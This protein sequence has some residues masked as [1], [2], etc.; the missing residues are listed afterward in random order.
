MNSEVGQFEGADPLPD[1]QLAERFL[2][3]LAPGEQQ[4]TFYTFDDDKTRKDV[5]LAKDLHGTLAEHA[6]ELER[7]NRQGAAVCVV[8][9]VTDGQGRKTENVREYRGAHWADIEHPYDPSWAEHTKPHA[10]LISSDQGFYPFWK[11]ED[12]PPSASEWQKTQRDLQTAFE[13]DSADTAVKGPRLPGFYHRKKCVAKAGKLP[14]DGV[15]RMVRFEVQRPETAGRH[16]FAED[17]AKLAARTR[18]F[19]ASREKQQSSARAEMGDKYEPNEKEARELLTFID[20]EHYHTWI[21]VG[22][23]L[24]S[25][26]G[27]DGF[28]IWD[29]WSQ[30]AGNYEDRGTRARWPGFG[31]K[32]KYNSLCWL[33]KEGGADLAAIARKHGK[34]RE[35]GKE[36]GKARDLSDKLL[37]LDDISPTL[38]NRYLVKGLIDRGAASVLYGAPNTGKTFLALDLALH[39][40]AGA[41]WHG[42]KVPDGERH[43]G[44]VLYVAAE[45]GFGITNRISAFKKKHP[46]IAARADGRFFLLTDRP[47]VGTGEGATEISNAIMK[48]AGEGEKIALI[49]IDTL[50]R[51][52][53]GGDENSPQGMG[54][55]VFNVDEIR[56]ATG[57]HV[58]VIHHS[59][60]D[61]SRGARGHN[62]LLG[63]VDTEFCLERHKDDNEV[64]VVK[65]DKQ[66]D[67]KKAKE[68]GYKLEDVHL[69]FDEDGE[70]VHSAVIEPV[71][72][73][74]YAAGIAGAGLTPTEV[75]ALACL[76]AVQRAKG[77]SDVTVGE[78]RAEC[79]VFPISGARDPKDQNKAFRRAREGLASKGVIVVGGDKEGDRVSE[80]I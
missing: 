54:L 23:A 80:C 1:L 33:A 61:V 9:H 3:W 39:V 62:N 71:D 67:R 74:D 12:N 48:R 40:A 26:F 27:D 13:G 38:E 36:R 66:R 53:G 42:R 78:W 35:T 58:M 47:N 29:E 34:A 55:Y 7:L 24:K 37:G 44:S 17:A 77:V 32:V 22:M 72:L 43:A 46:E 52:M 21:N 60:K 49:V 76:R 20:A 69:G 8:A 4:F 25:E 59:G 10:I 73:A 28:D 57:A 70:E 63:G 11:F 51:T 18:A 31:D 50:S 6:A 14:R 56:A 64:I 79:R 19:L 30:T 15:P 2:E 75:N 16:A 41:E 5:T 68:I 65:N 45:G